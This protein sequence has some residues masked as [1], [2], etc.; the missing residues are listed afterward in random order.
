MW[1]ST[2][3]IAAVVVVAAVACYLLWVL[4]ANRRR[5]VS[6]LLRRARLT[7]PKCRGA[8]DYAFVPGA[9]LTSLRL[10]RGRYMACP[11]CRRW[12]YFPL[13][14]PQGAGLSKD[15]RRTPPTA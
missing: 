2:V 12:S 10:G 9:S 8:F 13:S 5:G 7:C 3:W 15:G 6:G 1:W 14:A 11:V 4:W